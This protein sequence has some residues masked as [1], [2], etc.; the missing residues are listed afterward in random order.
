[1]TLKP[2]EFRVVMEDVLDV[3]EALKKHCSDFD[4]LCGLIRLAT[5]NNAQAQIL[6]NLI[7][8]HQGSRRK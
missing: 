4:E 7:Q 8:A 6:H 3:V 2:E 1:M 5:E